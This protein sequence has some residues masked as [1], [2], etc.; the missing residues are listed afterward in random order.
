MYDMHFR[1]PLKRLQGQKDILSVYVAGQI[2]SFTYLLIVLI[3]R[4]N[5]FSSIFAETRSYNLEPGI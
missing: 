4:A 1:N 2:Q 3:Q 5:K